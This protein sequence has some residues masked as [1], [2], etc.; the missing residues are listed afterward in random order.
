MYIYINMYIHICIY[1]YMYIYT[2]SCIYICYWAATYFETH[3]C[4][5]SP[6]GMPGDA[7][8]PFGATF[9]NM[10]AFNECVSM[11]INMN[12]CM[13]EYVYTYWSAMYFVDTCM[14]IQPESHSRSLHPFRS[15]CSHM[16]T[17]KHMCL[18]VNKCMYPCIHTWIYLYICL[19]LRAC[20]TFG[21][22]VY[23]R[24]CIRTYV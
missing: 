2:Y 19:Y 6:S 12:V 23:V 11:Y 15:G 17:C 3:L 1:A 9:I 20:A 8:A 16:Y 21:A 13:C 14:Y 10:Y 18:Y 4:I 7:W 5:Y 24:M 22:A